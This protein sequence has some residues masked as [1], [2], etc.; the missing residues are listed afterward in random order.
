VLGH[1]W[2]AGIFLPSVDAV[3]RQ[4]PLMAGFS[5][6]T[7]A[8]L[9]RP[10]VSAAALDKAEAL[11]RQA[12]LDAIAIDAV[13]AG[14]SEIAPRFMAVLDDEAAE[15]VSGFAY[16]LLTHLEAAPWN[17][18]SLWWVAGEPPSAHVRIDGQLSGELLTQLFRPLAETT[19][20][21]EAAPELPAERAED[22]PASD[23]VKSP[24][25]TSPPET[26]ESA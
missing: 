4:F 16:P 3:G 12:L 25:V 5:A 23:R 8:L 20:K 21:P 7:L 13:L 22:N 19:A 14:L 1:D 24:D 17:Q 10:S 9:A 18:Q 15:P 11:L 26:E 6:N 2:T